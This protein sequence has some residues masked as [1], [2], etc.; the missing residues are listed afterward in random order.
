[1]HRESREAHHFEVCNSSQDFSQ[2]RSDLCISKL[3]ITVQWNY[4]NKFEKYI[5]KNTTCN[6]TTAQMFR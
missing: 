2:G 6:E 4:I 1:M 5:A 3:L